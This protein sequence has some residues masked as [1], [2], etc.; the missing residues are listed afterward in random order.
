VN[1]NCSDM[2]AFNVL[3]ANHGHSYKLYA[4]TSRINVRHEIFCNRVVNVWNRLP[5]SDCH[6]ETSKLFL[7]E[8]HY[9]I[10]IFKIRNL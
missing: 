5:T 10:N 1:V 8:Q 3:T 7:A 6:F 2:F 9:Y 4:K